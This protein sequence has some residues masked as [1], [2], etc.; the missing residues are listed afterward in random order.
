[1][2]TRTASPA[3]A[4][5]NAAAPAIPLLLALALLAAATPAARGQDGAWVLLPPN[6]TPRSWHTVTALPDGRA[7]AAFGA[8]TGD[9]DIGTNTCDLFD[10]AEGAWSPGAPLPG[11]PRKFHMAFLLNDGKVL[12]CGGLSDPNL[13][14]TP[15]GATNLLY[16]LADCWLYDPK[17]DQWSETGAL[18]PGHLVMTTD[19]CGV[20]LDDG[21]VLIAGGFSPFVGAVTTC[22]L[23]DPAK[24]TWSSAASMNIPH[25][26]AGTPQL[27]RN[28]KVLVCGGW[29][30][31]ESD[32]VAD[33]DFP[34]NPDH[35]T[36][37]AEVYDPAADRWTLTDPMPLC[38]AEPGLD[39]ALAPELSGATP[40]DIPAD[41]PPGWAA[42]RAFQQNARLPDGRVL[43][44][45]GVG[46]FNPP[47]LPFG[48]DFAARASCLIYDDDAPAGAR[49]HQAGNLN[50]PSV[51]EFVVADPRRKR[52]FKTSGIDELFLNSAATEIFDPESETWTP[53]ADLPSTGTPNAGGRPT[54]LFYGLEV[55]SCG[56]VL[57]GGEVLFA[58]G[59]DPTVEF[60]SDP[61]TGPAPRGPANQ[62]S[63]LFVPDDDRGRR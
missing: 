25:A 9:D 51:T 33:A 44:V 8:T 37:T 4:A 1:M 20:V 35:W 12:V 32:P 13:W 45:G 41:K 55:Y 56:D 42:R 24:G 47:G 30:G 46:P 59:L 11:S 61:V 57:K 29:A 53:A 58:F 34:T 62:L 39:P 54:P 43:V 3:G 15:Q 50:T 19:S 36:E 27:L 2:R 52:V 10:P 49:W 21:R 48:P 60:D 7:L 31:V 22:S 14:E 16:Y 5:A 63:A 40:I 28:G 38:A 23:Y 17:K 26:H 6:A 18:P